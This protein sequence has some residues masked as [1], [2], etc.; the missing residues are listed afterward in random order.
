MRLRL[1]MAALLASLV[2]S[3]PAQARPTCPQAGL[4]PGPLRARFMGVSTILLEDGK[5]AIMVDGFFSRPSFERV[6]FHRIDPDRGRITAALERAGVRCLAALL[7]AQAHH[8]HALDAAVVA[9]ETGAELIGSESTAN[10][11]LGG[12]PRPEQIT[13]VAGGEERDFGRFHVRVIRSPHSP[14]IIPFLLRG[15]I[16][17]PLTPPRHTLGYRDRLNFSFLV[18]HGDRRILIHPSANFPAE[19][20]GS[21]RADVVFLSIGDLGSRSRRF[22]ESYWRAIVQETGARLIIPIHWDNFFRPLDEPLVPMGGFG[23]AMTEI[24]RLA[25][26]DGVEV[27]LVPPF[28]PIELNGLQAAS[29]EAID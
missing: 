5:T 7:V 15:R 1:L 21:I 17:T 4:E 26:R 19:G 23:R 24:G 9:Y 18:T 12:V 2:L 8:D 3:S 6:A 16:P 27:R 14:G 13:P 11:G 28:A 20:M 22:I 10:I 29:P 25:A